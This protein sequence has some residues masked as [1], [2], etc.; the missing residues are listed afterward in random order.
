MLT[1]AHSLKKKEK[2]KKKKTQFDTVLAFT[3]DTGITVYIIYKNIYPKEGM[4]KLRPG[5]T[6]AAHSAF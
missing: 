1:S 2:E 6:D 4:G 3:S 5:G